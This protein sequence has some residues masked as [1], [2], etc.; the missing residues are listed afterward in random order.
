[1]TY[2]IPQLPTLTAMI[3][4]EALIKAGWKKMGNAWYNSAGTKT[5][6]NF[7]DKWQLWADGVN[8]EVKIMEEL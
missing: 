4:P 1:L 7:G 5:L 8:K 3:T 6:T 2:K